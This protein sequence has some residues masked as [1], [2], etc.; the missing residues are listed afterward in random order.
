VQHDYGIG[1][2]TGAL[3]LLIVA[4]LA[5]IYVRSTRKEEA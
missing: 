5:V 4:V 2:A 3:S 1:S